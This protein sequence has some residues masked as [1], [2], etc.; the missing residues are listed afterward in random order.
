MPKRT[1]NLSDKTD[2]HI[3]GI[4]QRLGLSD[5]EV[6][7]F[8]IDYISTNHDY[9]TFDL[10]VMGQMDMPEESEPDLSEEDNLFGAIDE[11]E[12]K[13]FNDIIDEIDDL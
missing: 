4:K 10:F 8:A 9:N 7:N 12:S 6:V 11:D 1:I 13:S 2:A 3:D 5:S